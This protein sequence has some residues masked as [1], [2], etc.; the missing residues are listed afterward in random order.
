[1]LGAKIRAIS[2]SKNEKDALK[3]VENFWKNW[4]FGPLCILHMALEKEV[5][6][7]PCWWVG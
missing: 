7:V 6:A 4:N 3:I 5:F 2:S 1:V